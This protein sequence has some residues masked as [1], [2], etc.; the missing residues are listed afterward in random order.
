M[1]EKDE[2][3]FIDMEGLGAMSRAAFM[4]HT[5]GLVNSVRDGT[6]GFVSDDY[7]NDIPSATTTTAAELESLHL[8]ERR[9][10]GYIIKDEE[11]VQ[12]VIGFHE[13]MDQEDEDD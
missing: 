5:A 4:L 3:T 10:G 12:Q 7:L 11:S 6:P 1:S 2:T 8:W 13:Q 9:P